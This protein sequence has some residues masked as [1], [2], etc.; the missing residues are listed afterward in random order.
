MNSLNKSRA[1]I[2]DVLNEQN[3]P[4]SLLH[5]DLWGGNYLTASTGCVL[6]D[7]AVYYGSREAEFG[8]ISLFG[9]FDADFFNGYHSIYPPLKNFNERLEFY[10][11][12]HYLNHL[13]IFGR[14]YL[15][16]VNSILVQ[17]L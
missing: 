14:G 7:P 4:N 1:K 10:K 12:Y 17:I 13:N 3:L 15:S 2:I 8:I 6:I 9:G 5:G 11:L 16:N